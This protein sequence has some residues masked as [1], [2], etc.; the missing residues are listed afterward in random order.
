M[1]RASRHGVF[2]RRYEITD[3]GRPVTLLTDFRRESCEFEV[4]GV[5]VRVSRERGKR[6]VLDGPGGRLASADRETGRR[7]AI[8]TPAGRLDLVRPSVWRS[9]WELHRG[10]QAVGRVAHDGAFSRASNADLPADLSL[11]VRVFAHYVVLMMW[12]RAAAAA[13]AAS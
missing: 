1:L 9:A 5:T 13:A 12:E 8:T 2:R 11:T 4:E 3:D 7:W 6:F 10:G